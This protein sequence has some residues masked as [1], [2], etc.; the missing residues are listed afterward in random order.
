MPQPNDN[1][2]MNL[3]IVLNPALDSEC[4]TEK[5]S[6][7]ESEG[8]LIL[9]S[10]KFLNRCRLDIDLEKIK[11]TLRFTGFIDEYQTYQNGKTIVNIGCIWGK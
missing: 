8:E 10:F 7:S 1:K 6:I 3:S 9:N 2:H 11:V 5:R 4:E